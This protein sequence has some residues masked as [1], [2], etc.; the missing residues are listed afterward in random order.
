MEVAGFGGWLFGFQFQWMEQGVS[1]MAV[2]GKQP[3]HF[4]WADLN[5]A[6]FAI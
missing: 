4:G 6:R 2:L 3:G 1:L 5:R